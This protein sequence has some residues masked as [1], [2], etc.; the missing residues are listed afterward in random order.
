M[1]GFLFP[2]GGHPMIPCI[3]G[4]KGWPWLA[5]L[6]AAAFFFPP[7]IA[8]GLSG[9]APA[10]SPKAKK[11]KDKKK[12]EQ[13][14]EKLARAQ[15]K[16]LADAVDTFEL[17]N[18]RKPTKLAELAKKQPNGGKPLIPAKLLIDPWGKPYKCDPEGPK[19]KGAKADIWTVT[20]AGKT[21]GNWPKK[22]KKNS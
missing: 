16:I 5:V 3:S 22:V 17:N 1:I 8:P 7:V 21:I 18:G 9:Q 6:V 14:K 12:Q 15:F 19:N 20:P 13:A 2:G 4:W 11:S 10:E